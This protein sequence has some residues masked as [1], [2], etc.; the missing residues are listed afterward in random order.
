MY[1]DD[2]TVF[3]GVTLPSFQ[4]E[5]LLLTTV[6]TNCPYETRVPTEEECRDLAGEAVFQVS[7]ATD[8]ECGKVGDLWTFRTGEQEDGCDADQCFC[9][10]L[11]TASPAPSIPVIVSV[12]VSVLVDALLLWYMC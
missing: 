8:A 3:D 12:G 9:T 6:P 4:I 2:T 10:P 7:E 5:T 11:S 1:T